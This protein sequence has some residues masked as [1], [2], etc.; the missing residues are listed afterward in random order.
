M[1]RDQL[2]HAIR[3]ACDVA[4]DEEVWVFGSQAILGQFPGA[5]DGLLMSVEVDIAPKNHP[6]RVDK[7]D[8]A[9]GELSMFHVTHDFYVHGVPIETALLPKGWQERAIPIRNANTRYNTGWCIEGHDL[10]VSKLAAFRDKD[11]EFVR[12]LLL[13]SLVRF[14]VLHER[15]ATLSMEKDKFAK[16]TD[17]LYAL[18]RE[19]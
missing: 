1:T 17:W 16:I 14:P 3:A 2:E 10:A 11:R 12:T 7:I 13:E 9:L 6:E 8:G 4:D 15:L 19:V 5:P 18:E